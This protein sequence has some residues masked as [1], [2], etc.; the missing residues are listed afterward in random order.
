MISGSSLGISTTRMQRKPSFTRG[1][2]QIDKLLVLV[3]VA[4]QRRLLIDHH[5]HGGDQFGLAAGLEPV[6]VR[7]AVM[8]HGVD[9]LLLLVDLDRIGAKKAAAI[10][11]VLHGGDKGFI[12]LGDLGVEDILDPQQHRHVEAALLQA[13]DDFRNGHGPVARRLAT[14]GPAYRPFPKPGNSRRSIPPPGT[15]PKIFQHSNASVNQ[16][17][18]SPFTTEGFGITIPVHTYG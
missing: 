6:M 11:E 7:A 2:R 5:A 9:D 18:L 13:F 12:Q 8:D 14:A 17:S 10:A 1:Q 16:P 3:A 15:I 4:D